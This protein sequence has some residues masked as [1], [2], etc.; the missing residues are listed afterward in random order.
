MN[1]FHILYPWC[2]GVVPETKPGD[3]VGVQVLPIGRLEGV[4]VY[5]G[6]VAQV[7]V[8][9]EVVGRGVEWGTLETL[10]VIITNT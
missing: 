5:D 7:V 8:Q 10:L 2:G 9:L 6:V 1:E 4:D 3:V